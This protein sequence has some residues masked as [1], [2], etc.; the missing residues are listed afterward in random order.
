MS[1]SDDPVVEAIARSGLIEP[2]SPGIVML[3]GGPDSV[4]LLAGLVAFAPDP[5]PVALHLNYGLREESDEDESA[6]AETCRRL[7]VELVVRKPG[8]PEGNLQA[9]ARDLRY[10]AAEE[11][12]IDR[13]ADWIA[14]GHT[15][16][17][18]AETVIYRLATSPGRRAVAA[19][20]PRSDAVIRPLLKL[21]RDQTR[22][23]VLARDLPFV[24][25]ISNQ[26]SGFSRVRIRNEVLPVLRE[27][28]PAAVSNIERTRTELLEEGDLVEGL[29][30]E[31]LDS[32]AGDDRRLDTSRLGAAHP[33]LRRI[34]LRRFAEAELGRGVPVSTK[35]TADVMRLAADPEGGR[36]DLGSGA[37]FVLESGTLTVESGETPAADPA[38]AILGLPGEVAWG[39]WS[40]RGER[41]APPFS[42][43]GPE[44]AVL[45]LA[46]TGQRLTVRSWQPGDRI[47]PLGMD[48]HKTLQDLFTDARVPRSRRDRIPV[49]LEG[50]EVVWVAGLAIG[51]R[52]RLTGRTTDAVVV[53]VTP[54]GTT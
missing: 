18:V 3:S 27:L 44:A 21:T 36:L 1:A 50:E 20:P 16:T 8:R 34:A 10:S 17:D 15:M 24:D 26:D 42:P 46:A 5:R 53:T 19:M 38:A 52:F 7:G 35:L 32:L 40:I 14:V 41:L 39:G 12:R 33:A 29:A 13:G 25:D 2:G 43:R 9:W 22:Q 45:D 30:A 4:A 23:Y 48:G 49:L 28:N 51:H 6:C 54:P 37:S 11:L 31:L 47:R